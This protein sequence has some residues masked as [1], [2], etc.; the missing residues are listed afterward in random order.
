[1][2]AENFPSLALRHQ[3]M[4]LGTF[5]HLIEDL[6]LHTALWMAEEVFATL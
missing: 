2:L 5:F 4:M 3:Q 6:D 1:V